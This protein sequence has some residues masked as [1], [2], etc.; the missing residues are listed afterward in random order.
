MRARWERADEPL[1]LDVSAL[2]A[3]I[4]PAFPDQVV[5][6][7]EP[8]V[9]GL[10]N[11]N[12][13]LELSAHPEPLLLRL[14]TNRSTGLTG[15][16]PGAPEKEAA[17]HRRLAP[18]LPV[19]QL[20][21]AAAGNPITGHAYMLREWVNGERLEVVAHQLGPM[22][23]K[24]LGYDIGS[25][26][27]GIHSVTFPEQGF[28]DGSLNVTP[29]PPEIRGGLADFMHHLLGKCGKERLGP[30][31]TQAL[32]EFAE[33]TDGY[34]ATWSTAPCL[35]HADF[36]G[37]NIL[38]HAD[39]H[40]AHVAAVVDWEFAFSGSPFMDFGNLLRPPLGELPGFEDA[41]ARGYRAAGGALPDD[42]RQ[43]SLHIDLG[44]WAGFLGRPR[45]SEARADDARRIIART[46]ENWQY[47]RG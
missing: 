9:G 28:L 47:A 10:A 24:E 19:P 44:A 38:V 31:L 22:E 45:I 18:M 25:V 1:A 13:R 8:T 5:A 35:T 30:Q 41:V 4:Q 46:L 14:Y 12:I 40:G 15:T 33:R 29:F 39:Q 32:M 36:G 43:R 2:T 23:L 16:Q 7:S 21:F 20:F 6:R 26:L 27:A 17:L 3:L 34:G 37:S 42:W 11:T